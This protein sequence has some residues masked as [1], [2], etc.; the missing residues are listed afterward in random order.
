MKLPLFA[1]LFILTGCTAREAIFF[2]DLIEGEA[3][4][5]EKIIDDESGVSQ[6]PKVEIVKH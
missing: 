3:Q 6:R 1:I 5:A 4:V 2:D